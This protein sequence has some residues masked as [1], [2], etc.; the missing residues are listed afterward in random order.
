M[1]EISTEQVKTAAS[2]AVR[3]WRQECPPNMAG[4]FS[5]DVANQLENTIATEV[6]RMMLIE[7]DEPEISPDLKAAADRIATRYYHGSRRKMLAEIIVEEISKVQSLIPAP[8]VP[9]AP[10]KSVGEAAAELAWN[11]DGYWIAYGEDS[12][13]P[14]CYIRTDDIGSLQLL[15]NI[16]ARAIDAAVA[17]A[18]DRAAKIVQES[19]L[20]RTPLAAA[21]R[22]RGKV[23]NV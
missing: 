17:E 20:T 11:D 8:L 19:H 5:I 6:F 16:H 10:A 2:E 22:E 15:R 12:K 13:G 18:D 3:R 4:L 9:P 21:I 7:Q 1:T 23:S 14:R